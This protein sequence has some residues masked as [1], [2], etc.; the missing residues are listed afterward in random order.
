MQ[1]FKKRLPPL[2]D[3]ALEEIVQGEA[4]VEFVLPVQCHQRNEIQRASTCVVTANGD[5]LRVSAVVL[6]VLMYVSQGVKLVP[7]AAQ[8]V[9]PLS[10]PT[11]ELVEA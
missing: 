1:L 10:S 3:H 9:H 7:Q 8:I 11:P 5:A 2:K 6:D 4:V